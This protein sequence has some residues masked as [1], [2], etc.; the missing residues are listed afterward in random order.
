[1]NIRPART[2]DIRSLAEIWARAFP[3]ERTVDQRVRQMEAGGVY[4]G[5]ETAW[6]AVDDTD[7]PVGGFR[8]Y[9]LMQHVHGAVLPMMG[10]AAVAVNDGARRRGLGAKL[11]RT[12][13][14]HAY[15][16]GDVLSVLYPFRPSFYDALGWGLA[17]VLHRYR[18]RPESLP[19]THEAPRV[20]VVAEPV[21]LI[22]GCYDAVAAISN[23]LIVRSPR[24]WRQH[25][26]WPG[27]HVIALVVDGACRA[28]CIAHFDPQPLTEDSILTIR[29]L[30]ALDGEA[31]AEL[32]SWVSLQRNQWGYVVYDAS[33]AEQFD[34]RLIEPR[35]PG[36]D[37]ARTLFAY[38]ASLIRG[39]MVRLVNVEK[40]LTHRVWPQ[41]TE[42]IRLVVT[43]D[44]IPQN[45]ASL[46]VRIS[47]GRASAERA[48]TARHS[49]P[50]AVELRVDV[51]TL[52][53][54]YLGE[55]DVSGA[56]A[57]GR[58]G[59]SGDAVTNAKRLDAI[60]RTEPP[61]ILFDEF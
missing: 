17:G 34:L 19:V 60:L 20:H 42:Q 61:F 29:E 40:A 38:T 41:G 4:G 24:I 57:L 32:L 35:T 52:T 27:L 7:R 39:P 47:G 23:G 44:I 8:A 28:Y 10:L 25:L 5:A 36:C 33:P 43:D 55:T 48:V 31:Y 49:S 53:Q 54:I 22:S 45:N 30:F 21:A 16:R 6:I 1:M 37:V 9:S 11:C 51:R 56:L 58:A 50:D 13:L 12:A 2:S 18:F 15:A 26:D 46:D 14:R 59:V 3:G